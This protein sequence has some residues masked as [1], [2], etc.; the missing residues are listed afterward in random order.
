M[1]EVP[2][3]VVVMTTLLLAAAVSLVIHR[4]LRRRRQLV[5]G[6]AFMPKK[7]KS[8][9]SALEGMTG[10][11][12]WRPIEPEALR[13][14]C[15]LGDYDIIVHKLT[16]D[17]RLASQLFDSHGDLHGAGA[18][19]ISSR[20]SPESGADAIPGPAAAAPAAVILATQRVQALEALSQQMAVVD[21]PRAV[22]RVVNRA[23]TCQLLNDIAGSP[24]GSMR[25]ATPRFFVSG[26]D[27]AS[28][29][30]SSPGE[31][32]LQ[33][34]TTRSNGGGGRTFPVPYICKP[35]DAC[36]TGDSHLMTL[37]FS[38]SGLK[39]VPPK[40]VVQEYVNHGACLFKTYVIG[41]TVRV[42]QRPSLPDLPSEL[43]LQSFGQASTVFDSQK[44]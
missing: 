22:A 44:P 37:V 43:E 25:L 41:R 38:E 10:R 6:F 23:L 36:G 34:P 24:V 8:M 21:P 28:D 7:T 5:V 13:S 39:H 33:E 19:A 30:S 15:L 31:R 1:V 4:R 29:T 17:V 42:F 12:V 32:P 11:V 20:S 18:T 16:D 3:L 40:T 35:I 2:G 26:S 9:R 14:G 27:A